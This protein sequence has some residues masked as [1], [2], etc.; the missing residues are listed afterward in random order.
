MCCKTAYF[1]VTTLI[2]ATLYMHAV[3]RFA[4]RVQGGAEAAA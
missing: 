4:L 1:Y 3:L 2:Q